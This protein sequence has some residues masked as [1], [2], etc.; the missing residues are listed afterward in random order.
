MKAVKYILYT[1]LGIATLWLVLCFFAKKSYHI[2][3]SIE[4]EASREIVYE[5]VRLFK[6]FTNWSPWHF[7]DNDMKTSI[8]GSDGEVGTVYKWSSNNKNVGKGSQKLVSVKP[9]RLDYDIDMGL[10]PSKSY[11]LLEGDSAKS[12][13]TWAM[14]MY[15][16]FLMKAG[17]LFTD[18]NGFVGKDFENGLANLKKYCEALAPK[19]YRGY[20]VVETELVPTYY[21]A[22]RQVVEFQN[23]P[24]FFTDNFGMAVQEAEKVGAKMAGHPSGLF[25]SYDTLAM[26]TDMAAGVPLDKQVKIMSGIEI[27]S[28]GGKALVIDYL[29]D[30]ANTGEA[31]NAMDDFMAEHKLQYI[32]PVI[33]EY[34]TDPALEPDTTKW[35]TRVIYYV[36]PQVDSTL[37]KK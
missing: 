3:R 28:V 17:G 37:Q 31:H 27:V 29:G 19:K 13:I 20:K 35:L 23:I 34:V 21:A 15:L 1:L 24:K 32:P 18:L 26:K 2:E 7:M 10:E 5:Q 11:F 30:Y 36:M 9:G 25:W 22:V 4:I 12:K 8:E 14:D 6:N 33:E 16:P